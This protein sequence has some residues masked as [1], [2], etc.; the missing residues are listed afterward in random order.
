MVLA[1]FC[2]AAILYAIMWLPLIAAIY[3]LRQYSG[4]RAGVD[5]G[6]LGSTYL[7]ILLMGG[8]FLSLGC[9]ASAVT[10]TQA[11]AGMLGL[12]FGASVFLLGYLIKEKAVMGTGWQAKTMAGLDIFQH[13]WDFSRG[14]IDTR[15][16][17]LLL[18]LAFFFLF[19]TLRFVESRRWK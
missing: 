8:V 2:A 1:K 11:T 3:I 10:R 18:S 9:L 4:D 6:A 7:G 16:V 15:P 17:L 13:M 19:L 12:F 5:T 14:I